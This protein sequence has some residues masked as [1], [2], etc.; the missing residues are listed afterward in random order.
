MRIGRFFLVF[1]LLTLTGCMSDLTEKTIYKAKGYT[2]EKAELSRGDT[3]FVHDGRYYVKRPKAG[4]DTTSLPLPEK[5]PG[6]VAIYDP[7]PAYYLLTPFTVA[8]DIVNLP[9][10]L[11]V[12][13][14]FFHT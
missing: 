1:S 10:T 7:H 13:Y 3:V 4:V 12:A 11:F 2:N 5:P 9:F 8:I 6:F 14:A